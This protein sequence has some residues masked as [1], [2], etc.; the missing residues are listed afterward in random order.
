M[1]GLKV[2]GSELFGTAEAEREQIVQRFEEA[3]HRGQQPSLDEYMPPQ[4]VESQALLVELVHADLE[5]RLKAG[6]RAHVEHYLGRYPRLAH[7]A[8]VV[9]GLIGAEW[10]QR[11]R[12]GEA[13][14]LEEYLGRFPQY[15]A[16]LRMASRNWN[17]LPDQPCL[18]PT[19]NSRP[20]KDTPPAPPGV[21]SAQR[22]TL[23]W[24]TAPAQVAGRN[25]FTTHPERTASPAACAPLRGGETVSGYE[26]LE[27]IGRGGM[28]V[29]YKARHRALKRLVA[30]KMILAGPYAGAGLLARFHAEAQAAARLQHPNLVQIYEVGEQ[31]GRPYLVLEFVAGSSLDKKLNGT[32]MPVQQAAQLVETLARAIDAA[33][34]AGIIHRDLKPANVLLAADGTPKITDFGL[35]KRMDKA[36]GDTLSGAVIGTPSYMAPEQASGQSKHIGPA[37]DVYALGAMLY[38]LLTG[39][40]PFRAASP[41][42]T[43]AQVRNDEPVSPRQLQ[44]KTPRDLETICLKCLQ[45][46][47]QRRYASASGLADD[48]ARFLRGESIRARPIPAWER[49]LNWARRRPAA[50]ALWAVTVLAVVG[51]LVAAWFHV[52]TQNQLLKREFEQLTVERRHRDQART[53]VEDLVRAAQAARDSR[54]VKKELDL[55]SRAR[56]KIK[57][58][59]AQDDLDSQ[60]QA[61][62]QGRLAA[63]AKY[64]EF[65]ERRNDALLHAT[66][67]NGYGLLAN[68]A[69][70]KEQAQKALAVF[71]LAAAV[72]KPPVPEP[73]FTPD[74]WDA[75][76]ADCY[77][78]LL[79]LAEAEARTPQDDPRSARLQAEK[80][81][82][83]LDRAA[84]LGFRAH[85]LQ[86][87]HL[88][89]AG[90]LDQLR[91]TAQAW[92]ERE[93]AK[94][95]L[96]QGSLD[97]FL[98]G[99]GYYKQGDAASAI[100]EFEK[101]LKSQP[102]HYWARYLLAVSYVSLKQ[103]ALAKAHLDVCLS[104]PERTNRC[105][106]YLVRGYAYAQLH[107]YKAAEDDFET[108]LH[109]LEH[110]PS[111]DATYALYN[112]RALMRIGQQKY[113][114]GFDDL[115]KAIHLIPEQY[116]AYVSLAK[117]YEQQAVRDYA[118]QQASALLSGLGQ[119]VV[120]PLLA[121]QHQQNQMAAMV[122]ASGQLDRGVE[123]AEQLVAAK[124]LDQTALAPLYRQRALFRLNQGDRAAALRELDRSIA[125]EPAGS[126]SPDLGKAHVLRGRLLDE[127]GEHEQAV[128]AY[129]A[130]LK[131]CPDSTDAYHWRALAFLKLQRYEAAI[132]DCDHY[133]KKRRIPAAA[134]YR[135][136]GLARAQL[137][138]PHLAAAIEDFTSALA[139]EPN[140][141]LAHVQRGWAYLVSN[142][143]QPAE[144][145][146]AD[147]I[148]LNPENGE[149]YIGRGYSRAKQ[150]QLAE[151]VADADEAIRRGPRTPSLLHQAACIYTQVAAKLDDAGILFDRRLQRTR[152]RYQA[153]A[154]ELIRATLDLLPNAAA[155]SAFWR[156]RIGPDK[157]LRSLR[158]SIEFERLQEKYSR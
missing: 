146:F 78:L 5:Y 143:F 101:A 109:L 7:D 65:V 84:T 144:R 42:D 104:H 132:D 105:W 116:R 136:R 54:D 11:R 37:A 79:V 90:Y 3:W 117:G 128:A 33:H 30:L 106:V 13:T 36:A 139:I 59:P 31:D 133:L 53:E 110:E 17:G 21:D 32:P 50:A 124:R 44:S 64:Q 68:L 120:N 35:A 73:F 19:V 154:V 85:P 150:G 38:E 141:G 28:G 52:Q 127:N 43:L 23:S 153:R 46:E 48:L 111:D 1:F 88:R 6:K 45:K 89:R 99:E 83:A 112:N 25:P 22:K 121:W 138:K 12:R 75:L 69:A 137:G 26:I 91:E 63:L 47:T 125:A 94:A 58:E 74:E 29:V 107:E 15:G 92:Q 129:S 56:D 118:A 87:Y 130:A 41:L 145:D 157:E 149:A 82:Q 97:H 39:R 100:R 40:P 122:K 80:A 57:A 60:V 4:G 81:R 123:A 135:I 131:G 102:S 10:E 134:V 8:R 86:A 77:Q 62:V 142:A 155:R 148:R 72:D 71:G 114:Q 95:R 34:Q 49:G 158:G 113:A 16:E 9:L 20:T 152:N 108:A 27:E 24:P 67:S 76:I 126:T 93:Q 18:P 61:K 147:G 66:A 70:T 55:L 2:A 96:P 14:A 119:G 103:P 156:E 140:D 51:A 151:A 115:E 98:L